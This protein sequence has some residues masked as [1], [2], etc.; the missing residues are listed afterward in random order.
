MLE[1]ELA[2]LL[3]DNYQITPSGGRV[4]STLGTPYRQLTS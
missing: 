2:Y 1:G 3:S 4:L